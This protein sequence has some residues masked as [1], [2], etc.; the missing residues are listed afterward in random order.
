MANFPLRFASS[1][2]RAQRARTTTSR[3]LSRFLVP[4]SNVSH[5]GVQRAP[6]RV[7][8]NVPKGSRLTGCPYGFERGGGEGGGMV[9]GV[10]QRVDAD[11]GSK[12]LAEPARYLRPPCQPASALPAR[13]CFP[14]ANAE[15]EAAVFTNSLRLTRIARLFFNTRLFLYIRG[16]ICLPHCLSRYP[17]AFAVS[18]RVV[19]A[20]QPPTILRRDRRGVKRSKESWSRRTDPSRV[21]N[22]PCRSRPAGWF[23]RRCRETSASHLVKHPHPK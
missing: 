15:I 18:E 16:L 6:A 8:G 4:V 17:L 9:L 22:P 3:C 19:E 11:R 12:K 23:H 7:D 20:N 21:G 13:R 2:S 5:H 1:M 10:Q 14:A